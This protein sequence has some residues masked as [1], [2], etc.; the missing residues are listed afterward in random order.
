MARPSRG[1]IYGLSEQNG[2]PRLKKRNHYD[3]DVVLV[4]S[5]HDSVHA[6]PSHVKS[7]YMSCQFSLTGLP[8]A[9]GEV[10]QFYVYI[11]PFEAQALW[12]HHIP[13]TRRP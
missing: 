1:K 4:F 6:R 3:Y 12:I 8:H 5:H 11:V 9:G 13:T 7:R 10:I 2:M